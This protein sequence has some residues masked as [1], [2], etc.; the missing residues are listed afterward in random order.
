MTAT[1]ETT[2]MSMTLARPRTRAAVCSP[3]LG[4]PVTSAIPAPSYGST[5]LGD[6]GRPVHHNSI[7]RSDL[8]TPAVA[9]RRGFGA[10]QAAPPRG[11]P[12]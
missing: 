12:R 1:T 7:V 6:L 3:T 9:G 8:D 4:W 11:V 10:K 5:V 2:G